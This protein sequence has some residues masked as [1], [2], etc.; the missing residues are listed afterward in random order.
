MNTAEARKARVKSLKRIINSL[1]I[2]INELKLRGESDIEYLEN[3]RNVILR[4]CDK[5]MPVS[6]EDCSI[7]HAHYGSREFHH[8]SSIK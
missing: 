4:Y 1:S 7:R 6:T 8:H 3:A 5:L 2:E